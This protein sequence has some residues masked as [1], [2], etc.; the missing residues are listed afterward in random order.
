[1][2]EL[3]LALILC[4]QVLFGKTELAADYTA[5]GKEREI[6][7]DCETDAAVYEVGLD[8]RSSF[9]S[10]HQALMAN[11][12]TGKTPYIIVIDTNGMED[13]FEYQIR[14]T[15]CRAGIGYYAV[16]KDAL[17]RLQMTAFFRPEGT[18]PVNL[19]QRPRSA[20]VPP[21]GG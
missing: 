18:V 5:V 3:G 12:L 19:L 11:L 16:D 13:R 2:G 21:A 15:A 7:I 6:H 17:I 8:R 20:C 9:D 4:S 10:V 1:M 14:M